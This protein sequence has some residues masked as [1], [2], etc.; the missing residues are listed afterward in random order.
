[1][2]TI[3]QPDTMSSIVRELDR[4]I[5]ILETA[6]RVDV[7]AVT[8]SLTTAAV[9]TVGLSRAIGSSSLG[10]VGPVPFGSWYK[11]LTTAGGDTWTDTLGNTGTGYPK[12]T[13]TT[14]HKA[15]FMASG[16]V[17]V[18]SGNAANSKGCAASFGI[19]I[20]GGTPQAWFVAG[21]PYPEVDGALENPTTSTLSFGSIPYSLSFIRTDLT[22]GSHAFQL[23]VQFFANVPTT[24]PTGPTLIASNLIVI[25]ID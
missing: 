8:S 2:S 23:W 7:S 17:N 10:G 24:A 5:R 22:P 1:M 21:Q 13:A 11:G 16:T 18:L 15:M 14:G 9:A 19:G 6:Q 3:N 12:V 25:P 4:R 20:D